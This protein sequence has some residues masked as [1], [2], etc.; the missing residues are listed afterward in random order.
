M[1]TIPLITD[2]TTITTDWGCG[3]ARWW[4]KHEN[5]GGIVPAI[6]PEYLTD[7]GDIH[8]DMAALFGGVPLEDVIGPV[9][10]GVRGINDQL[11]LESAYRRAA[12]AAGVE[13]FI[14]PATLAEFEVVSIEKELILD[15]WPLWVACTPDL[16]L[17]R[18]DNPKYK[19]YREYKSTGRVSRGWVDH[20]PTAVQVHIGLKAEEEDSGEA[21][22]YGE[23]MGLYKGEWKGGWL[24]HPY[25]WA[26]VGGGGD[27]ANANNWTHEYKTGLERHPVWEYPDGVVEWVKRLGQEV[28][29]GIFPFS[30]PIFL[31]ETMLDTMI[32]AETHRELE[33]ETV[34]D[35]CQ[36]DRMVR[37]RYFRP[38]FERCNPVIGGDCP[39]LAACHNKEVNKSPLGSGLFVPREPHHDVELVGVE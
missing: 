21:P 20:W 3:Q 1:R 15:R 7:G 29:A 11:K 14:K 9:L 26:W 32:E 13:L 23:V 12:W 35:S 37:A 18:R 27:P 36:N 4:Y 24:R 10:A 8:L 38:N 31:N 2:R 17:R 30:A 6:A 5:G 19:V 33:I 16:V 28:A 25:V 34:K 22:K 39:Y